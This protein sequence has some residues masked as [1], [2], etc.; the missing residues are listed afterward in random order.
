M[1]NLILI[2]ALCVDAMRSS[3]RAAECLAHCVVRIDHERER[4]AVWIAFRGRWQSPIDVFIM[5]EVETALFSPMRGNTPIP[6]EV[7]YMAT[8]EVVQ[9]DLM[10]RYLTLGPRI[11][12]LVRLVNER[13]VTEHLLRRFRKQLSGVVRLSCFLERQLGLVLVDASWPLALLSS[14]RVGPISSTP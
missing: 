7:P 12:Y 2:E 5:K 3:M 11:D 13:V 8:V 6:E 1:S 10:Q 14:E 4:V 9:A